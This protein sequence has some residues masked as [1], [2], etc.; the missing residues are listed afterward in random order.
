MC[1]PLASLLTQQ[2]TME[3]QIAELQAMLV[4]VRAKKPVTL[5]GD[6]ED[7]PKGKVKAEDGDADE[8]KVDR[9][10]M[11]TKQPTLDQVEKKLAQFEAKLQQHKLML[12]MKDEN[13]A[14][15]LGTAKINYMEYVGVVHGVCGRMTQAALPGRVLVPNR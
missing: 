15:A 14:V 7:K 2:E 3:T 1:A 9:S 5:R 6:V 8:D 12:Q 13:K 11:F 4:Q 10:H